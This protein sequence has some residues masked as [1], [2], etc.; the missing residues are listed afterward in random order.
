[1]P[2]PVSLSTHHITEYAPGA[3]IQINRLKDALRSYRDSGLG[4]IDIGDIEFPL[5]YRGL[6]QASA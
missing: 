3:L 4:R 1:M 5:L 6:R 2:P